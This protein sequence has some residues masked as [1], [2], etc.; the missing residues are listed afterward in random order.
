MSQDDFRIHEQFS[1]LKGRNVGLKNYLV[2]PATSQYLV[3]KDAVERFSEVNIAGVILTKLDECR[4]LG[5]LLSI[6]I[7]YEL[8][9]AYVSDGQRVPEDLHLARAQA[10]LGNA[11][12]IAQANHATQAD[13]A[14]AVAYGKGVV[15]VD[16]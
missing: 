5:P 13:Q 6:L 11:V 12:T 4:S 8:P 7:Q 14:V 1:L 2:L 16:I 9:I 3:L 10:L 15:D